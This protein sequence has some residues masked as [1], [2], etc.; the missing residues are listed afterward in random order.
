MTAWGVNSPKA[1]SIGYS[2]DYRIDQRPVIISLISAMGRNRVIGINNML[3]WRLPADLKHFKQITMGKPVLMG[4]KT[5][6]SIG[7]PLPGR[8]N[9][10]ISSDHDYQVPGCIVAHSIDDAL[11]A[12]A[13]HEEVMVI[14]GAALYQQLLP[15]A[16][17]LYLTL[18]DEDFS[19]DAYFPAYNTAAWREV[20]RQDFSANETN[21]YRHSFVIM[22]RFKKYKAPNLN[23]ES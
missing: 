15:R 13:S 20:E 18:I 7:K 14:G 19:G 9:I 3:P 4:R 10:I 17:R 22:E 16:D 5:Y 11:T 21:P 2:Y 8:T 1:N 12:A 23:G 6:E